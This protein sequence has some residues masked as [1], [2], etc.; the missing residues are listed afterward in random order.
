[1]V[2]TSVSPPSAEP[3]FYPESDGKPMSE[4][5]VQ[6]EWIVALVGNLDQIVDGF[7]A[8]DLFWYPVEG[9]P[10][11]VI[12]PDALVSL[13]RPKGHRHSY[14]QWEEGDTPPEVVFEVMSPSNDWPELVAKSA[15]CAQYG[16]SE[17]YVVD[18][19]WTDA[20]P[21]D[22]NGYLL[23]GGNPTRILQMDGF[24][25]P[26]L[27]IRF[28]KLDGGKWQISSPDGTP[29][30]TFQQLAKKHREIQAHIATAE[31]RA[32]Q[33]SQRAEQESQRA[34]QESQ[35]AEQESQRAERL[36]ARLRELGI[37]PESL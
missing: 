33:E 28:D 3:I 26:R 35:R 10:R 13:T 8:G 31:Q 20:D 36:A 30:Y 4:N 16:V 18:P 27:G 24:V 15:F 21:G 37:D 32:E 11:V 19:G 6:Y 1:V 7:V 2:P 22:I 34:E 23:G 12:A 14:K 17:M 9:E 25:S 5:T 29:F